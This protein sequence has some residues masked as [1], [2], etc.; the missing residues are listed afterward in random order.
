MVTLT[1]GFSTFCDR[2]SSQAGWPGFFLNARNQAKFQKIW[3]NQISLLYLVFL[4]FS[5]HRLSFSTPSRPTLAGRLGLSGLAALSSPAG[6]PGA[7]LLWTHVLASLASSL[8]SAA[9]AALHSSFPSPGPAQHL[10]IL[11]RMFVPY[12]PSHLQG[13]GSFLLPVSLKGPAG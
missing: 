4:L 9:A 6:H 8:R 7:R 10:A 13:W 3:K 2:R 1:V 11:L 5:P 12:R